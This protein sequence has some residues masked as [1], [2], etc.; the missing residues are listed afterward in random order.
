MR[1]IVVENLLK[2]VIESDLLI[3]VRKVSNER[4][5]AKNKK[6]PVV[7]NCWTKLDGININIAK[8]PNMKD[9]KTETTC[10]IESF[11][12]TRAILA[13]LYC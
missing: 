12:L 8:V 4:T 2:I 6:K 10:L 3:L 7:W 1:R 11:E 13:S 9:D 5:N